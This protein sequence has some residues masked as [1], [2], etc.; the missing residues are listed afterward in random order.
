VVAEFCS[1]FSILSVQKMNSVE[2]ARARKDHCNVRNKRH[3]N[4]RVHEVRGRMCFWSIDNFFSQIS[5]DRL[6]VTQKMF[7]E[8]NLA[9]SSCR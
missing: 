9:V 8:L 3:K 2:N 4:G 7:P 1:A 5:S 6:E